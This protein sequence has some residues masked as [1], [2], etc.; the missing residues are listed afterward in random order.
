M[1]GEEFSASNKA[2]ATVSDISGDNIEG[3]MNCEFNEYRHGVGSY[4]SEHEKY[5]RD[6]D[7]PCKAYVEN[8]SY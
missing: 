7:P 5:I 6:S 1:T 3:C 4:C 8:G 2:E